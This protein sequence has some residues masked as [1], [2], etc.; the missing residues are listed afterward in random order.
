MCIAEQSGDGQNAQRRSRDVI[1]NIPKWSFLA[2]WGC[3]DIMEGGKKGVKRPGAE[4]AEFERN[5]PAL[6]TKC[7]N[8]KQVS[9]KSCSKWCLP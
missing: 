9:L 3:G 4:I 5:S 1:K 8:I 6:Q 2:I 7:F